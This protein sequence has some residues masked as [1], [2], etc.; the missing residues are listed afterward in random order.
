MPPSIGWMQCAIAFVWLC[1]GLGVVHP[2]YREVGKLYLELTGFP[3]W[4]MFAACAAEVALGAAV[5]LMPPST[6]ITTLQVVLIMSFTLILGT[7]EPRLLA[8][9]FGVLTKNIPLVTLL[10]CAWHVHR[11]GWKPGNEWLLRLGMA[12]IWI[13]EGLVPKILFQQQSELE[14]VAASG[15]VPG[16]PAHFLVL[17]GIFQ[18]CSG[19]AALMLRGRPLAWILWLQLLALVVLPLLV[20]RQ[21]PM[22]WVHPFGPLTKNIPIIIGTM[23]VLLRVTPFLS[24]HWSNILVVSYEVPRELLESRI[25]NGTKL[26]TH[27]GQGVISLVSLDFSHTNLLGFPCFGMRTFL[28]VNLRCYVRARGQAGVVFIRELVPFPWVAWGARVLFGEPFSCANVNSQVRRSETAIDVCRTLELD[29]HTSTV[30]AVAAPPAGPLITDSR[31]EFLLER[32][33]GF[34]ATNRGELRAFRVSHEPWRVY[35][36][37]SYEL[38]IDWRSIYGEPWE[39]LDESMPCSVELADGSVVGVWVTT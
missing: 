30:R 23:I 1:T 21:D 7:H 13:T 15:L 26:D 34:N 5:L 27:N 17:M 25:P 36:V 31:A 28:D 19:I 9:P 4:T 10:F 22:L 37:E 2:A 11:R 38:D 6:W 33:W 39:V 20:A 16:D 32:Y 29:G 14:V 24:A 18:I 3:T 12:I 8:H 35:R